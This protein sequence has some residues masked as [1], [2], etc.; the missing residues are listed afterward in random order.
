MY[1][2]T[3]YFLFISLDINNASLFILIFSCV[4][5]LYISRCLAFFKIKPNAF[6]KSLTKDEKKTW[7]EGKKWYTQ[8]YKK[9]KKRRK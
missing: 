8:V 6:V 2:S 5:I 4:P 1:C 3:V 7:M 9:K